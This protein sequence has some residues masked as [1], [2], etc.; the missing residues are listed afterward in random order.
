VITT[1]GWKTGGGHAVL[2]VAWTVAG[3][4][5]GCATDQ[6]SIKKSQGY[7]QEGMADLTRDQQKAFVSFQ[8]AVQLNP[9]NKEARY[10]LGHIYFL[11]GKLPQAEA[12]FKAAVAIDDS[13]S[14]AHNYLGLVLAEQNRWDDAI[15]SYRRALANP[16]YATPDKARVNL[17]IALSHQGDLQ[18]AMEMFEDALTVNPPNVPPEITQLE[19]GRVYYKM[20]YNAKA[21]EVLAKVAAADKDG[22]YGTEATALLAK[23]KKP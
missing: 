19:L 7:Y 10:G 1:S 12:E 8:K 22:R 23:L 15:K 9:G 2:A 14:E 11:Q 3:L 20:G 13:Y 16:L 6:E 21:R 18:G 5:A 17:G 4:L